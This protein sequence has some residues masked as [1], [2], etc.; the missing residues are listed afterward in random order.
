LRAYL[1]LAVTKLSSV[2]IET[3]VGVIESRH[4][5]ISRTWL[6]A[7]SD[8]LATLPS[9]AK[10]I[11]QRLGSSETPGIDGVSVRLL[12]YRHYQPDDGE[13]DQ[14]LSLHE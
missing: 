11:S 8:P 9:S 4:V 7:Q 1:D 2:I 3:G 14:A 13:A 12:D 5:N 10:S 6:L